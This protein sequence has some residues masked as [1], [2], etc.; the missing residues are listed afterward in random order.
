[1]NPDKVDELLRDGHAWAVD[2]MAT[3]KEDVEQV[4]SFLK[5]RV[6]ES[7]VNEGKGYDEA[8]KL[9]KNLREKV[10]RKLNDAEL[11]EF[12]K[13]MADHLG[14]TESID[15]A[16][17]AK[18]TQFTKPGKDG[19]IYFSKREGNAIAVKD[20]DKLQSIYV[21]DGEVK[22]GKIH[23]TDKRWDNMGAPSEKLLIDLALQNVGGLNTRET[24]TED[25]KLIYKFLSESVNEAKEKVAEYKNDKKESAYITK[26]G[27]KYR[28][29]FSY[30]N[31][32]AKDLKDAERILV[33]QGFVE[34]NESITEAEEKT[35]SKPEEK[36]KIGDLKNAYAVDPAW[37]ELWKSNVGKKDGYEFQ[38]DGMTKTYIVKKDGEVVFVYDFERNKVFTNQGPEVITIPVTVDKEAVEDAEKKGKELADETPEEAEDEETTTTE[39]E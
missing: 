9:I 39:E 31:I 23:K 29:E 32:D 20:G 33:S 1:M 17:G 21:Y 3:A 28:V 11:E 7:E 24:Q 10:Y 5:A 36:P 18:V 12:N 30:K 19:D 6:N 16:R 8:R 22:L 25:G 35:D 27:K 2:H 38:E 4:Y 14:L 37:W 34:V 13:E 26:D 15:E